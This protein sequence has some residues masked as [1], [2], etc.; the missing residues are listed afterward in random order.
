[1]TRGSTGYHDIA[2]R[3]LRGDMYLVLVLRRGFMGGDE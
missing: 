1:M 2:W 3:I